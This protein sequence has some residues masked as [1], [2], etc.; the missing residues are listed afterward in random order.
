MISLSLNR[1][2]KIKYYEWNV[3]YNLNVNFSELL[4]TF[5][6]ENNYTRLFNIFNKR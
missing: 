1:L 6:L 4:F 3:D 2:R 5:H